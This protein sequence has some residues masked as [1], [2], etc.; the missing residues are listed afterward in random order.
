[1]LEAA[2][3]ADCLEPVRSGQLVALTTDNV[4]LAGLADQNAGEFEVV[5][6]PFTEEPYGIGLTKDDTVFRI[7]INDVLE[8]AFED[9]RWAAAWEA[10]A[11][12][13]LP[14]RTRRRSTATRSDPTAAGESP[15]GGS[16][17]LAHHSRRDARGAHGRRRRELAAAS[18]GSSYPALLGISGVSALVLGAVVAAMRIS[19]VPPLRRFGTVYTELLRNTP[20]TLVLFV[21][22]V[23]CRT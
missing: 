3:Y 12:K 16:R 8:Q 14:C 5:G 22:R 18:T 23:S 6:D 4:I 9:G 11:G 13:V 7:W 19:P 2:D 10:T 20:L 1:M 21:L 15:R 17:P